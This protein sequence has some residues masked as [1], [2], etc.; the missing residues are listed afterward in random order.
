M[1]EVFNL[2]TRVR[3]KQTA[4]FHKGAVG[5]VTGRSKMQTRAAHGVPSRFIDVVWVLRDRSSDSTWWTPEELEVHDDQVQ[6][7]DSERLEFVMATYGVGV[8]NRERIDAAM[9]KRAAL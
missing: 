1:S 8:V 4:G 3:V 9:R 2:G 7:T 6:Y 5:T